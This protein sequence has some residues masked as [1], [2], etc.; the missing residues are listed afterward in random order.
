MFATIRAREP[1]DEH[2]PYSLVGGSYEVISEHP[3][4]RNAQ[5]W[6]DHIHR[7]VHAVRDADELHRRLK[8]V[9]E[10]MQHYYPDNNI[11]GLRL[12]ITVFEAPAYP[13]PARLDKKPI[14]VLGEL[15]PDG[16]FRT[17]LGTVDTHPERGFVELAPRN[18]DVPPDT[19]LVYY[20]DAAADARPIDVPLSGMR[21]D[22]GYQSLP[23]NPRYFVALVGGTPWL[24]GSDARWEW[25]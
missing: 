18:V 15:L 13:A 22:L 7:N 25:R 1:Y 23:G 24:V 5:R 10:R 11:R 12:W 9:L 4:D 16:T 17:L 3:L 6:L 19:R 14:A 2:R 21:F 8:T 20:P